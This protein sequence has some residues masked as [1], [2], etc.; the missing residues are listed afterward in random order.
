MRPEL[1]TNADVRATVLSHAQGVNT[2][3]AGSDRTAPAGSLM[4]LVLVPTV[5]AL[6]PWL[7]LGKLPHD[8]ETNEVST[9]ATLVD[10]FIPVIGVIAA[11]AY[12]SRR[13]GL[14]PLWPLLPFALVAIC[15]M[16]TMIVFAVANNDGGVLEGTTQWYGNVQL[17][18]LV[19]L[20]TQPFLAAIGGAMC[21]RVSTP[22]S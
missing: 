12:G 15:F 3:V 22:R 13:S 16:A 20:A 4:W 11:V 14:R 19:C 7:L 8:P 1:S 18:S 10:G 2:D 9:S 21:L 17:L 5:C 6:G